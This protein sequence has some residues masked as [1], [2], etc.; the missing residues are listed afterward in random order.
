MHSVPEVLTSHPPQTPAGSGAGAAWSRGRRSGCRTSTRRS[1]SC[2]HEQGG[3]KVVTQMAKT[4]VWA[5]MCGQRPSLGVGTPQRRV[6]TLSIWS[7]GSLV[8]LRLP[9]FSRCLWNVTF[10]ICTLSLSQEVLCCMQCP[11][12]VHWQRGCLP[13]ATVPRTLTLPV[14]HT[15]YGGHGGPWQGSGEAG[16]LAPTAQLCS[17]SSS[18]DSREMQRKMGCQTPEGGEREIRVVG[19][20]RAQCQWGP[21]HW[22]WI[23]HRVEV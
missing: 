11:G 15:H 23:W 21:R 8:G 13:R 16:G 18:P 4:D 3:D 17:S 9:G 12:K 5:A 20:L 1:P 19:W 10:L 14:G 7:L 6:G 2:G 22:A